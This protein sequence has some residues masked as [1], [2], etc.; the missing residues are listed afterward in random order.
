MLPFTTITFLEGRIPMTLPAAHLHR[1]KV[2]IKGCG[3]DCDHPL[4]ISNYLHTNCP[5]QNVNQAFQRLLQSQGIQS[6]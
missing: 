6:A 1:A 4:D 3:Y 2:Y 5:G